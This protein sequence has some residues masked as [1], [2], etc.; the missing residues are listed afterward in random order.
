M[1]IIRLNGLAVGIKVINYSPPQAVIGHR[2]SFEVPVFFNE[3]VYF[4]ASNG[5]NFCSLLKLCLK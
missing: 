5:I 4:Q 1:F 3:I 2:R